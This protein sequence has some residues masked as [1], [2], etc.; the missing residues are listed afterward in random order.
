MTTD[1]SKSMNNLLSI[2]PRSIEPGAVNNHQRPVFSL[3]VFNQ[4]EATVEILDGTLLRIASYSQSSTRLL[5][6]P[7]ESGTYLEAGQECLLRFRPL[8]I[9]AGWMNASSYPVRVIFNTQTQGNDHQ[10][11]VLSRENIVRICGQGG[12]QPVESIGVGIPP[13]ITLICNRQG[14]YTEFPV[15]MQDMFPRDI[16]VEWSDPAI[17]WGV[18][19][20]DGFDL[21]A[22]RIAVIRQVR[23]WSVIGIYVFPDT[24]VPAGV[25]VNLG[26][27]VAR[28]CP[29]NSDDMRFCVGAGS[30]IRAVVAESAEIEMS[31]PI[32]SQACTP[33]DLPLTIQATL[34]NPHAYSVDLTNYNSARLQAGDSVELQSSCQMEQLGAPDRPAADRFRDVG[35]RVLRDGVDVSHTVIMESLLG[36]DYLRPHVS[37]DVGWRIRFRSGT[38]VGQYFLQPY[39]GTTVW[40]SS[41]SG[42]YLSLKAILDPGINDTNFGVWIEVV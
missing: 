13:G 25:V 30:A 34:R 36:P 42:I 5:E 17:G 18:R 28:R 35:V 16:E 40:I 7:I 9:R 11:T 23:A 41:P 21:V 29:V 8:E 12:I 39:A 26:T 37:A 22:N 6:T 4:S 3:R 10:F 20:D 14:G 24:S 1:P 32:V 2:L 19:L 33:V 38:P 27:V 15:I 31:Q